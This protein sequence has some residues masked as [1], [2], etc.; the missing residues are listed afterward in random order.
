MTV[1]E[2]RAWIAKGKL[3]IVDTFVTDRAFEAF[4]RK[5]G[6]ELNHALLG[7]GIRDWL[8]DEYGLRIPSG[9]KGVPVSAAEKHALVTRQCPKCQTAMRGNIFFRHV[10]NCKGLTPVKAVLLERSSGIGVGAPSLP[11]L[12]GQHNDQRPGAKTQ[13]PDRGSVVQTPRAAHID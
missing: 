12:R 13:N 9:E 6:A 3:K 10:K 4:C 5:C 7:T 2:V 11:S 1:E 8:V